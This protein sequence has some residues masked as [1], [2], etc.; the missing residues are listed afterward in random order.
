M[1]RRKQRSSEGSRT[2][3]S[4]RNTFKRSRR[5]SN[6]SKQIKPTIP[7]SNILDP[8]KSQRSVPCEPSSVWWTEN[9]EHLAFPD[10]TREYIFNSM[11]PSAYPCLRPYPFGPY[12]KTDAN[13]DVHNP[14]Y[15]NQG[16]SWSA[17]ENG[18][19]GGWDGEI[20]LLCQQIFGDTL[21]VIETD[22]FGNQYANYC[23]GQCHANGGGVSQYGM[24]C[25]VVCALNRGTG[26]AVDAD[27]WGTWMSNGENQ[28][29][30]VQSQHCV[31]TYG[32]CDDSSSGN[33]GYCKCRGGDCLPGYTKDACGVCGGNNQCLG[34]A[35]DFTIG[36]CYITE[37]TPPFPDETSCMDICFG[38]VGGCTDSTACNYNC[39]YPNV[40][41]TGQTQCFDDVDYDIQYGQPGA[42]VYPSGCNNA[43]FSDLGY[44]EC[45]VCGGGC[46]PVLGDIGGCFTC[47]DGSPACNENSCPTEPGEEENLQLCQCFNDGHC[48]L[49]YPHYQQPTCAI[50]DI[51]T[52]YTNWMCQTS[53]NGIPGYTSP[54]GLLGTDVTP[55]Q[56]VCIDSWSPPWDGD[57]DD[58]RMLARYFT[59]RKGGLVRRIHSQYNPDKVNVKIR[60]QRDVKG[61]F[62]KK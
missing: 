61:K 34:W 52:P 62:K 27:S 8:I 32:V 47:W 58:W 24:S 14:I 9:Y 6:I 45:G 39:A 35:C 5:S 28:G 36:E 23:G 29:I 31:G 54:D 51:L 1:R 21:K 2:N 18:Y 40:P 22:P 33:Y 10:E 42:C 50:D 48:Y 46:F 11:D 17:A 43:C 30:G 57:H 56:G 41:S 15:V 49:L 53:E 20:Q 4:S 60:R 7:S 44:D 59:H 25:P 38:Q 3:K 16:T 55:V 12:W 37:G 13:G 26:F 19:C